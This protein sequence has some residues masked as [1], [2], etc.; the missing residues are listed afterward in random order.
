MVN[1]VLYTVTSLGQIAAIDPAT[2]QTIWSSI[3]ELE[4][5]PARNLGFVHRGLAYWTDG[6]DERLLLGTHDAYLI[7]VDAKTGKL[8]TA[9]G[10]GGRVDLMARLA[11]ARAR[12]ATTRSA[13]RR[14]SARTWSS[15]ARPSTTARTT[16]SGRA[17]T[18]AAST[19]APA[20]SCGRSTRFR[21]RASSATRP[22]T[23]TRGSTP[24]T[25][26]CG[27]SCRADEELGY[28]YLPF[29]TP[30]NDFYGG[31]RPGDNLFAESLVCARREDRQARLALPGRASRPVGLRLSGGADPRRHH[32]QRQPIKAV[33]QVSKQGFT[34]VF[35]RRTG[36]PVWPIEERPVPQS[37]VPGRAHVADAAV[38]DQ[39]AR[40]RAPGRDR[41]RPDRLHAGAE[42]RGARGASSSTTP[43]RSS[44]RR[45]RRARSCN[46]G[47]AGG[48]NWGG[49]AFDP[50]TGMLYVPSMTSPIVVQLVK[51]NAGAQQPALSR[52]AAR[53]CRRRSTGC[54]SSSRRTAA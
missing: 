5:G 38:P 25:P 22:G 49:A 41:E 4:D 10:D 14:S 42:G 36:E 21:R 13:P 32:G 19:C 39:A 45:R 43:G 20:S 53:R 34:Y 33:A 17:A 46:P 27:R 50:E 44:R 30:T 52:A 47:W 48:A 7:S 35:D 15:S 3:P 23:T 29:G 51:P 31:H 9:F 26:T 28:V 1:G 16:R 37:T 12:H 54:R 6:N 40:V 2:G 11:H 8:D 24:A 18:S